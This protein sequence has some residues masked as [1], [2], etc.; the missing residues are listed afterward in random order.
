M[1]VHAVQPIN[2]EQDGASIPA[3]TQKGEGWGVGGGGY[4]RDTWRRSLEF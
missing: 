2:V 3:T 4:S 1:L